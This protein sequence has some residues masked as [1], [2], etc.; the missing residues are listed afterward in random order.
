MTLAGGKRNYQGV[1]FTVRKR[2]SDNWQALV[3]YTYNDAEG[4]SNSDGNADFQGDVIWLDPWSP[5]QYGT[6][7]GI[8]PKYVQ[9]GLHLPVRHGTRGGRLLSAGT[10]GI[11]LSKTFIAS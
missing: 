9:G 8:D 10:P 7:A 4:N 2:Y 6:T 11:N 5:N 1:E 3:A